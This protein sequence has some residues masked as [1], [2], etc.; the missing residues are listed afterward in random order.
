MTGEAGT[1]DVRFTPHYEPVKPDAG[2]AAPVQIGTAH[3]YGFTKGV[4]EAGQSARFDGPQV[5]IETT[6]APEKT[7]N[8]LKAPHIVA[9]LQENDQRI[10]ATGGVQF[11]N[12]RAD[13]KDNAQVIAGSA[14]SALFVDAVR[15][16]DKTTKKI[17]GDYARQFGRKRQHQRH[18]DQPGF[19]EGAC[20]AHCADHLTARL[21]DEPRYII[22]GAPARTRFTLAPRLASRQSKAGVSPAIPNNAVPPNAAVPSKEIPVNIVNDAALNNATVQN[23]A[24]PAKGGIPV[25]PNAGG[26][27]PRP[28]LRLRR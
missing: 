16:Q 21:G 18:A 1:N 17:E 7:Q 23:T 10:E 13:A 5:T 9:Q 22:T 8:T 28:L 20:H 24:A 3:I 6:N 14:D 19:A 25:G 15:E 12:R 2:R 27:V 11:N 26:Q 4:M